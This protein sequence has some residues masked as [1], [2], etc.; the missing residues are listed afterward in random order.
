MSISGDEQVGDN[1]EFTAASIDDYTIWLSQ[2]GT[3]TATTKYS[4]KPRS[5]RKFQIRVDKNADLIQLNTIIFTDPCQITADKPHIEN[6]NVPAV[7]KIVL[8]TN[9]TNTTIKIRWF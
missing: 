2:V 1:I 3:D 7:G 6:R 8:R 5:A 4:E 9:S